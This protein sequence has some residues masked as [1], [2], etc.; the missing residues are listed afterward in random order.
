MAVKA[1]VFDVDGTLVD[2][3][4][5]HAQ[6]WQDALRHF[7]KDVPFEQLRSQ[8]GKG[9]DQ[10][11]PLFF[12]KDEAERIGEDVRE[13]EKQAF[14]SRYMSRVQPF[15]GVRELFKRIRAAGIKTALATSSPRPDLDHNKRLAHIED[16][17][18]AES[19]ADDAERSKPHPDI[20]QAV[21]AQLD[22]IGPDD[23]IA[24]GDS[25]YDAE[26]ARKAGMRAIGFRCGGFP[27]EALRE[28][29]CMALYDSPE[30]LLREF[31]S[32]PLVRG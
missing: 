3:V 11:V 14:R 16:L 20:F 5:L 27:E 8:I 12:D 4:D 28:A 26:A 22:G 31:E 7:G 1:A 23:A 32:S 17:V 9:G 25:P 13:Y 18:D 24:I 2:S 21:L 6:A 29:G 30:H 10:I 19:T 15:P